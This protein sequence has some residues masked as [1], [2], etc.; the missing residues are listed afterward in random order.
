MHVKNARL[1]AGRTPTVASG[2]RSD[3]IVDGEAVTATT[4]TTNEE[5]GLRNLVND[6]SDDA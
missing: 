1:E 4:P 5:P 3:A 6:I 2:S